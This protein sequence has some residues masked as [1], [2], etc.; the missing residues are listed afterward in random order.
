MIVQASQHYMYFH[1]SSIIFHASRGGIY[2]KSMIMYDF[3][4]RVM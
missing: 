2:E 4:W 3:T 1:D